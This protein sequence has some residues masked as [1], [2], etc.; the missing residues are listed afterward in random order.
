MTIIFASITMRGLLREQQVARIAAARDRQLATADAANQAP[1]GDQNQALTN[2]QQAI[3]AALANPPGLQA[4]QANQQPPHQP[5]LDR[6][7]STAPFDLASRTGS[8]VPPFHR[9]APPLTI[10][11]TEVST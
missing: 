7:S 9:P 5:V 6:F 4:G 1:N 3:I 10:L 2:P 8:T 11:G